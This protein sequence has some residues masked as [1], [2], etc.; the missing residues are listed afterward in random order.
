MFVAPMQVDFDI[1]LQCMYKC[2]HCNVSAGEKL[3]NE[4]T[5]E[6]IFKII[7]E[8]DNIGVS[9]LS[10]TGG[11]PLIR[12]DCLEILKYA[13][14]K[15][16]IVL[17]LNTNGLLVD[18]NVIQFLEENCKNIN[19]C[20]S[21]DGYDSKTYSVLR[22]NKNDLN[23]SMEKQFDL[24]KKNLILLA[25][26]K[27][28]CGVNYTITKATLP[29][30]YKTFDFIE[31][32]GI[33][34]MLAIKFFPYG[35]GRQNRDELELSYEEWK[36]FIYD[37]YLLKKQGKYRNLQISVT[38]PWEVYLPSKQ[39]NISEDDVHD[40]FY[41]NSPLE[42]QLYRRSRDLGCHA[43]ITSCAISPNGDVYPCGT[44]SSNFSPFICGNLR[45]DNML[46][47]WN[48][49]PLLNSLRKLKLHELDGNCNEC[50]LAH[51]CGG[52][53]RARAFTEF[54]KLIAK[55]YLCPIIDGED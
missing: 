41:Y 33:K 19:V 32:L 3:N 23:D 12:K 35:Y 10:I 20:V 22:K 18:E 34:R 40:L 25:N 14:N 48:K 15:D 31:S 5:T 21:L 42:S 11:E 50:D 49:S 7:D 9:D 47:I 51:L 17:T 28:E 4:L 37:L 24:V 55:D 39:L 54:N 27:L 29:N 6:E 13:A 53:C 30:I 8:L 44:I 43:G 52:G 46:D 45:V 26:S 1:T 2:S 36:K 38:C 16:A